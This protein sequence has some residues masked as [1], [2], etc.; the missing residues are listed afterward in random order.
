M[1]ILSSLTSP[2]GGFVLACA[3]VALVCLVL[4]FAFPRLLA[5]RGV[6]L[7]PTRFGRALVFDS[8]D[9]DETPL[10]LLNVGGVFQSV[11]YTAPELADALACA[12][13]RSFAA[14]IRQ[15]KGVRRGLV[16]GGGGFAL[17][18]HLLAHSTRM[19]LDVVEIDPAII[20]I[21]REYFRLDEIEEAAKGRLNIV[22]DDAWTYLNEVESSFDFV[23]NDAFSRAT[24]LGP[25]GEE[26]GA[27]LIREKIREG[28]IYLANVR[29]ALDGEDG[30][31][32]RSLADLF[33]GYFAHVYLVPDKPDTPHEEGYNAFIASDAELALEGAREL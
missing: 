1:P 5:W 14:A 13:H 32:I 12:Y 15:V 4:W 7:I 29:S 23:V 8:Y 31:A 27:A 11:V 28:G 20:G 9:E 24:P 22:C 2:V 26:V 18:A 33:H 3:T 6:H 25:L 21:A 19:E 10:R 16:M 17:P 30:E